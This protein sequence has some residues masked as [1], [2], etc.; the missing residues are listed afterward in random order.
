MVCA[1]A[2]LGWKVTTTPSAGWFLYITL[3]R[4]V[5][6]ATPREQDTQH[7]TGSR[8]ANRQQAVKGEGWTCM[9]QDCLF[10]TIGSGSDDLSV[11]RRYSPHAKRRIVPGERLSESVRK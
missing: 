10:N 7:R 9:S 2:L 3:P 11:T 8:T 1:S 4:T 5:L 6:S